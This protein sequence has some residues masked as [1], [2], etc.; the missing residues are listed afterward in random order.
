MAVQRILRAP[1]PWRWGS[2]CRVTAKENGILRDLS[3]LEQQRR[4]MGQRIAPR[5]P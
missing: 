4:L 5:H 3:I 2:P 1:T